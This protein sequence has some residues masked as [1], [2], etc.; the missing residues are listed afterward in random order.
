MRHSTAIPA[1]LPRCGRFAVDFYT[2]TF[3]RL[4]SLP[5]KSCYNGVFPM[6]GKNDP[7]VSNGWKIIQGRKA[8]TKRKKIRI[9]W[10]E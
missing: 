10:T 7:E 3:R 2:V 5:R 4:P 8:A 6:P 1:H 9:I